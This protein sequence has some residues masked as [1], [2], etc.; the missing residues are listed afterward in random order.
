MKKYYLVRFDDICPTMDFEQFGRAV[1]LMEKY[2]IKPL[3]GVIPNNKDTDQMKC[4]ENPL[5]WELLKELQDKGWDIA[6]HGYT[7]VYDQEEPKTLISGKKHSEFAGNNY[8]DQYTKIKKGKEI[9][10]S[11][12][13][14]TTMFFAPAHTYDAITLDALHDNGF[15]YNVDGCSSLPYKEQNVIAI[16]CRAFGVP[17]YDIGKINVAVCHPSVWGLASNERDYDSLKMFCEKHKDNFVSFSELM[18]SIS[19]GNSKIQKCIEKIYV[20]GRNIYIAA[21]NVRNKVRGNIG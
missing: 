3:L 4:E 18:A 16:P 10:E 2:N 17:K 6:L 13:L 21:R 12:G 20:I 15:L 8:D 7:H 19:L 11:H 14:R 9:L 5:F 1:S